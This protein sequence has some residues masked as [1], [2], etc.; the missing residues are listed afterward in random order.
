MLWSQGHLEC[1]AHTLWRCPEECSMIAA[2]TYAD[3]YLL[4]FVQ[5]LMSTGYIGSFRVS[6]IVAFDLKPFTRLNSLDWEAAAAAEAERILEKAGAPTR[7]LAASARSPAKS[8][9]IRCVIGDIRLRFFTSCLAFP[10]QPLHSL[11][12]CSTPAVPTSLVP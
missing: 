8:P 10:L 11:P 1:S 4:F 2:K 9:T 6:S 5:L 3:T 7:S 12:N